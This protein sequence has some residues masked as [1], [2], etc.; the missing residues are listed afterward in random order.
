MNNIASHLTFGHQALEPMTNNRNSLNKS[1]N[2]REIVRYAFDKTKTEPNGY[3]FTDGAGL[4]RVYGQ[5]NIEKANRKG[6]PVMVV[7][8]VNPEA[9]QPTSYDDAVQ[10]FIATA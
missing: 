9:T 10:R 7:S 6:L 4:I 3:I 8:T 5:Q 2:F 1:K